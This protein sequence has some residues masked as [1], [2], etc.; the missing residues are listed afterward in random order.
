[1]VPNPT[2]YG[3]YIMTEVQTEATVVETEAQTEVTVEAVVEAPV[4]PRNTYKKTDRVRKAKLHEKLEAQLRT[5]E[6]ALAGLGV[7]NAEVTLERNNDPSAAR[8]AR[9]IFDV[10]FVA[11]DKRIPIRGKTAEEVLAIARGVRLVAD[12]LK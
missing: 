9:A 1:M 2:F 6:R 5:T 12:L 3:D 7:A 11:G 4:A 8:Y 10:T